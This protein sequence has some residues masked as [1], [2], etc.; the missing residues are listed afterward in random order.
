MRGTD[1]EDSVSPVLARVRARMETLGGC[2]DRR[3]F[4]GHFAQD[5]APVRRALGVA[6]KHHLVA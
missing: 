5:S 6:T 3:G 1:V 2:A 4:A